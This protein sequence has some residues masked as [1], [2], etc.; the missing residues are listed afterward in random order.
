MAE[1]TK[2]RPALRIWLRSLHRDA[3]YVAVGLTLVYAL[4]GLAV[5]HISDWDPNFQNYEKTHELGPL[6]GD[7]E[8]I[9]SAVLRKLGIDATPQEIYRAAPEQLDITL[10]HRTLHVD[11]GTG[12]VIDEGQKPRLLIRI[13]NWLHLNRGKRSWTY[14]ADAYA[15]ALLFLAISGMFM[16]PGRKGLIGRGGVLVLLGIAVPVAYVQLSGGPDA[17]QKRPPPATTR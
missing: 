1:P 8:A 2:K 11:P 14:I 12:R 9:S 15:A 5:N 6:A 7:D 3:G 16:L 10:S 13:A 4:S 17:A